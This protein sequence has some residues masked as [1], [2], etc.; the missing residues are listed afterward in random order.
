MWGVKVF[1][2]LVVIT[3]FHCNFDS[4]GNVGNGT[5]LTN[6]PWKLLSFSTKV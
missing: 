1:T 4:S 2:L 6:S 3:A 5:E